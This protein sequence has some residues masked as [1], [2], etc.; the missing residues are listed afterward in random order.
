MVIGTGIAIGFTTMKIQITLKIKSEPNGEVFGSFA[1]LVNNNIMLNT[2]YCMV[3][4]SW[5]VFIWCLSR[6]NEVTITGAQLL[7]DA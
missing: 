6:G 5:L 4:S 3:V 2:D 7:E 1:F